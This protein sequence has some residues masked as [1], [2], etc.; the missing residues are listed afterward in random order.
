MKKLLAAAFIALLA[1]NAVSDNVALKPDGDGSKEKPYLISK[2][3]H[4][5]WMRET[6][7]PRRP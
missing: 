5:V 3:E 2:I 1:L 7:P 4:L 6:V